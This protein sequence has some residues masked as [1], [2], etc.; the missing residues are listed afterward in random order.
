MIVIAGLTIV[1]FVYFLDPTT[2]RRG[3]GRSIFSRGGG[4][5]GSING[6]TISE[7]EFAQ[8]KREAVLRFFLNYQRWPG[9]DE[10]TRQMFDAD[11][12]TLEW[13]FLVEKVNELNI[14]VSDDA[15]TDWIANA[16]RDRNSGTF[17]VETYQ[18]FI[19]QSLEHMIEAN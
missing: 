12:Q 16:F 17:R 8:M 19:Q 3:R 6:R 11:R 9:E 13:I 4:D 10:T 18:N 5:Y 14:K 7:E 15:V 1:S 2:G